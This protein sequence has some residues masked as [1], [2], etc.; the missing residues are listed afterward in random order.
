VRGAV[1]GGNSGCASIHRVEVS[2]E[3]A[4]V[5]TFIAQILHKGI[6]RLTPAWRAADKDIAG[7]LAPVEPMAFGWVFAAQTR[8]G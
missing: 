6:L 5:Q 2:V 4:G 3:V 7:R 8:A 1:G